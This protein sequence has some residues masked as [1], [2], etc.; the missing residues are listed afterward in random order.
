MATA[1]A[2]AAIAPTIVPAPTR[3]PGTRAATAH[4]Q[5][6]AAFSLALLN[7]ILTNCM[8][9]CGNCGN[10]GAAGVFLAV[11][12]AEQAP[13]CKQG[14]DSAG[15]HLCEAAVALLSMLSRMLHV[16]VWV[17]YFEP[18]MLMLH[19]Y[20]GPPPGSGGRAR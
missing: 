11:R 9:S 3:A 19:A 12:L 15:Q 5:G 14:I 20:T 1:A 18:R 17:H 16:P 6:E 2:Q 13:C 10:D 4:A 8:A 7:L